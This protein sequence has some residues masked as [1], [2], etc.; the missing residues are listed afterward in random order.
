M[1]DVDPVI[2]FL[3]EAVLRLYP[4]DREYPRFW[5]WSIVD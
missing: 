5:V 2:E 4:E 3:P 1:I